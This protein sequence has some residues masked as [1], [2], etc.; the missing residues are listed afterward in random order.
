MLV[1]LDLPE[2][3]RAFATQRHWNED[4]SY[5]V[6]ALVKSNRRSLAAFIAS[7]ADELDCSEDA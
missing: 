6:E 7:G 3:Y 5:R 1:D 4:G 2:Q